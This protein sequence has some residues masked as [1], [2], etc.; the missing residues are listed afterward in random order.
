MITGDRKP[1]LEFDPGERFFYR[2]DPQHIQADGTIYPPN[3]HCPDLSSNRSKFSEDWHVL[4]PL[5]EYSDYAVFAFTLAA[6]P[7]TVQVDQPGATIYEVHT[8]HSPEVDNYAHCETRLYRNSE[9]MRGDLINKTA[10]KQFRNKMSIAL[11]MI[12]EPHN[13]PE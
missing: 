1:V 6:L 5:E 3:I 12:R 4:F 13:P 11:K 2:V 7:A 9:R 10:K 8:V